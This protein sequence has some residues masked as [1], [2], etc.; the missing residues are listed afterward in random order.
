MRILMSTDP[1]GGVW[2]YTTELVRQLDRAGHQVVLASLGR[3]PTAS[4]RAELEGIERVSLHESSHR[5]EWMH[6]SRKELDAA[7][8][9][10]TRLFA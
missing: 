9:W 6:A 3:A 4:Q 7:A 10:L 1:I 5:L 8:A 2:Q